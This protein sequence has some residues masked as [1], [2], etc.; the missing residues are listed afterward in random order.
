MEIEFSFKTILE[1]FLGSKTTSAASSR[2][3]VNTISTSARYLFGFCH[4]L[5][6]KSPLSSKHFF[7]DHIT[8]IWFKHSAKIG[9]LIV[10]FFITAASQKKV[11]IV[12]TVQQSY[13]VK[14]LVF[15]K[16]IVRI[17]NG[18]L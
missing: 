16:L 5:S 4:H 8:C 10:P 1:T 14:V 17:G 15:D 9:C 2:K 18:L 7:V 3:L 6:T 11:A 13:L 12:M